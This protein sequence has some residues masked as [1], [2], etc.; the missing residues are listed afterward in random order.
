M[1]GSHITSGAGK[2]DWT[3]ETRTNPSGDILESFTGFSDDDG[4]LNDAALIAQHVLDKRCSGSW[5]DT[6]GRTWI[7]VSGTVAKLNEAFQVLAKFPRRQCGFR[8]HANIGLRRDS[9]VSTCGE[10]F[11]R[12]RQPELHDRSV[13]RRIYADDQANHERLHQRRS[14]L[15]QNQQ[16]GAAP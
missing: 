15:V 4:F 12:R 7:K 8:S 3:I 5:A 13:G 11:F 14:R 10:W 6:G 16:R 2:A 1:I 9:E